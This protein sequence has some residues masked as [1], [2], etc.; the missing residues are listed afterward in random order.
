[1]GFYNYR[2]PTSLAQGLQM[3]QP[4]HPPDTQSPKLM[5]F[6]WTAQLG[7]QVSSLIICQ[8]H[9]PTALGYLY[10]FALSESPFL[11]GVGTC[12]YWCRHLCRWQS[13]GAEQHSLNFLQRRPLHLQG[14][15]QIKMGAFYGFLRPSPTRVTRWRATSSC[16]RRTKCSGRVEGRLLTRRAF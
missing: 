4:T 7:M 3:P 5:S 13:D 12:A 15:R 6:Q 1:M 8:L 10:G 2:H 16:L 11:R 9:K 14:P